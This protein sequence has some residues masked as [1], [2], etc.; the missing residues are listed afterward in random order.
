MKK[1][2]LLIAFAAF[3]FA[4]HA[5]E[6]KFPTLD[7]SPA[8]LAYFPAAATQM[9]KK[10]AASPAVIK[11]TYSRPAK[12]GREVFGVLE[13]FGKVYRLGANEST[14]IKFFKPVVIGG[15]SIPAGSYGLFAIPNK[16]S[17]TII[18][19]KDTDHWGAYSYD[20]A[21]DLVRVQVPVKALTTPL[22]TL[23]MAFTPDAN[24]AVLNIG[25]DTTSVAVPIKI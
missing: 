17:W 23:S 21:N 11:V 2:S 12:K 22:E 6:V 13:P 16:D 8:D 15:K 18:V 20:E 14:E 25:W 4:V 10:G 9:A 1:L 3:A 7:A 5:Q 19:S 24:G